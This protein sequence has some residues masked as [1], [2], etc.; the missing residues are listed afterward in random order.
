MIILLGAALAYAPVFLITEY[1]NGKIFRILFGLLV[2]SL[3]F[4]VY[5]DHVSE[6]QQR[7]LRHPIIITL[8][9][10]LSHF[11]GMTFGIGG[12]IL[13]TAVL[14]RAGLSILEAFGNISA[15]ETFVL[16]V[17]SLGYMLDGWHQPNLPAHSLGFI[18]LPALV[19]IGIPCLIMTSICTRLRRKCS[20]QG[21]KTALCVILVLI[22]IYM[23]INAIF[24]TKV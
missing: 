6:R 8:L 21:L 19:G 11:L 18:Y 7:L 20:A 16:L 2:I 17:F 15:A 9:S 22:G 24:F 13:F 14:K 12:G 1:L 4:I 10:T 23:L 3:P 5:Q